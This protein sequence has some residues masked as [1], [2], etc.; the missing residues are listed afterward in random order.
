MTALAACGNSAVSGGGGNDGGD[1]DGPIRIGIVAPLSGGSA[2]FGKDF[3]V[4]AGYAVEWI[5]EKDMLDGREIELI[6]IDDQ[7]APDAAV[8]AVRELTDDG[9]NIF[10]GTVNSPVA[11]A[12]APVMEQTDSVLITTASHA[13][14]MTHENFSE[15]VFRATDNPF[16]RHMAQAELAAELL[17]DADSWSLVGPDH[18]YGVSTLRS[19]KAGLNEFY[20]D[21][22]TVNDAV[23]TAFGAADY[24]QPMSA[25]QA[26]APDAVFSSEY[27]ADAVTAYGQAAEMGLWDDVVLMDSANGFLIPRTMKEDTPEHWTAD[28]WFPGAYDNEM[29]EFIQERY[30]EANDG[31]EA[32][33]FIGTSFT[34]VLVV[35][36]AVIET[37]GSTA[38]ADLIEAM[39]GLTLDTPTG[40]LELR[41]EDHQGIKD[42]NFMRVRGCAECDHGYEVLEYRVLPGADFIEPATPGEAY[43][44]G[45]NTELRN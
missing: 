43:D 30:G 36:N 19:F 11:M 15:N 1:E 7:G 29:S 26:Q 34:G 28:H 16:M 38:T 9:V 21:G 40:E 2:V 10:I 25:I 6:P 12:L 45:P 39:E 4:G 41:A 33:G 22:V 13:M 18:A 35:A 8:A 31:L 5:E 23:M 3:P 32:T 27:A 44:Y 24:R 37:D 20:P 17:P 42:L 14:E